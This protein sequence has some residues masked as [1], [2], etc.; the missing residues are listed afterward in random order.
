MNSNILLVISSVWPEPNS[1][2]AGSRILQLIEIYKKLNYKVI[3][4]STAQESKF[5]SNLDE[6][7]IVGVQVEMNSS[8]FDYFIKDLK[9]NIVLFDRFIVEEQFGWRV[10]LNSPDSFLMLDTEDLHFL[11]KDRQEALKKN[12]ELDSSHIDSDI[13]KREIA[14]IFRCDLTLIISE[15]ELQ[16]L[17]ENFKIP[18]YLLFYIPLFIKEEKNLRLPNYKDRSDFVFIGNFLHEPNYDAVLYIKN[19]IWPIIRSKK[20]DAIIKIYGA[21][22]SKKVLQLNNDKEGFLVLGRAQSSLEIISNARIMLA[23]IRFGAGIKGK[24]LEAMQYGTPSITTKIGAEGMNADFDWN[25][26]ISDNP[27]E[28]ANEA[29]II[30]DDFSRWKIAQENGF[31]II[32]SRFLKNRFEENFINLFNKLVNNLK[33][34]RKKNFIGAMLKHHL[35]KSNEYMSKWI[36][37]KNKFKN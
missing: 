9:P 17:Q 20:K 27:N 21:Y 32:K 15:Y 31:K 36:E 24:L 11:R 30:Y 12:K 19:T 13:A 29:I 3:Y 25:G 7:N 28:F 6:L 2:A 33:E 1:S 10:T 14:S 37:E 23:P 16:Y 26:F 35:L 18:F 22:P 34:H 4:A 8:S 5:M